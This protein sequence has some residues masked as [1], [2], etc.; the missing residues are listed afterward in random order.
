M[1]LANNLI[2]RAGNVAMMLNNVRVVTVT[3]NTIVDAGNL[4]TFIT[5]RCLRM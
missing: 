3:N 1:L 2:E 5:D 4:N